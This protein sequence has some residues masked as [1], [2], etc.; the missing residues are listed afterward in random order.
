M[1]AADTS[2]SLVHIQ[3]KFIKRAQFDVTVTVPAIASGATGV[4]TAT[5]KSDGVTS[6]GTTGIRV[7]D[8]VFAQPKTASDVVTNA[9][10]QVGY[11]TTNGTVALVF[12]AASGAVTSTASKTYTLTILGS[13][14]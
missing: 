3:E 6:I 10:P 9:F 5:L 11:C 7:G 12:A 1:A 2:K 14:L 4:V 13:S 8:L